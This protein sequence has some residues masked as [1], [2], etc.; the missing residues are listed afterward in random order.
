MALTA[1]AYFGFIVGITA[2]RDVS[3]LVFV[4][5]MAQTPFYSSVDSLPI[6][7]SFDLPVIRACPSGKFIV[8]ITKCF[9]KKLKNSQK[10]DI[11]ANETNL[12]LLQLL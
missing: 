1:W 6:D 7:A 8:L 2:S 5:L 10:M 12:P 11:Y 9:E 4:V 3:R